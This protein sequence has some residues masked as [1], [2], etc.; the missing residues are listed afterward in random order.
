MKVA[1]IY[2]RLLDENGEKQ[3]IGG[4]ETYL[5]NLAAVC[6]ELGWV[7][8]LFQKSNKHFVRKLDHLTVIGVPIHSRKLKTITKELYN[9]AV[10]E[11]DISKDI[12]I[13]GGDHHSVPTKNKRCILIQHGVYW[14]LPTKNLTNRS[15]FHKS[16]FSL[17]YK[18]RLSLL[19][20]KIFNNCCY[21]VCVDYNYI[22]WYRT[23]VTFNFNENIWIIPNAT[24]VLTEQQIAARKYDKNTISI[25]FARRFVPQRGTRLIAEVAEYITTH[26]PNVN[27]TF[28]GDGP[29]KKWLIAR[30]ASNPRIKFITYYPYESLDIHLAHDI[31]V[32]PSI[33]SEGTSLS[34]AEAMGAGCVVVATAVGGITNMI[35]DNFNGILAMPTAKSLTNKIE[36]VINDTSL[37]KKLSINAYE[38]AKNSFNIDHWKEKWKEVLLVVANAK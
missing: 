33:A 37:R 5:L 8:I 11:I 12:I 38:T 36:K 13:F 35:I 10:R 15:F 9:S 24:R 16:I 18:I 26:Y 19:N 27:F 17:F 7:P 34:V 21:K 14:D 32:I 28:A 23:L 29:D 6:A 25:L 2:S 4:V 31:A 30:L 1:F 3:H 22:N 20:M